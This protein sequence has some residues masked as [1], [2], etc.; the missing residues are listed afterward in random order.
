MVERYEFGPGGV[1]YLRYYLACNALFGNLLGPLLAPREL[2]AGST[3][4]FLPSGSSTR[5]EENFKAGGLLP[6]GPSRRMPDGNVFVYIDSDSVDQA[7][8]EW[9]AVTLE[10]GDPGTAVV[11]VEDVV[12][13]R[14]QLMRPPSELALA[15]FLC[16]DYVYNYESESR[17][18]V[19][20]A[21]SRRLAPVVRSARGA[22]WRPNVGMI[23]KRPESLETT[24]PGH[25]VSSRA[26]EEMAG[27]ASAIIVGAWDVEAF[28]IWE[29]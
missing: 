29:P 14:D 6:R 26:L 25:E 11:C 10:S 18:A 9:V 16:E 13:R 19:E 2:E 20:A 22:Y 23:T 4:A 1:D 5:A 24:P 12:W 8:I 27:A 15:T 17:P 28:L 7:V 21:C 3:W